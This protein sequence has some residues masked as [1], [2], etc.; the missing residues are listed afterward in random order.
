MSESS[1]SYSVLLQ[2][3]FTL[4]YCVLLRGGS[5]GPH[6]EDWPDKRK[7]SWGLLRGT[8]IVETWVYKNAGKLFTWHWFS[9][10]HDRELPTVVRARYIYISRA[11]RSTSKVNSLP[12]LT[13]RTLYFCAYCMTSLILKAS[14]ECKGQ[15]ACK[16]DIE[17]GDEA[18]ILVM[19]SLSFVLCSRSQ[20]KGCFTT[21]CYTCMPSFL[22]HTQLRGRSS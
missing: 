4:L 15:C 11:P 16:W 18:I 6:K 21:Q 2:Y 8:A 1:S 14:Y 17:S 20:S 13:F 9:W 10:Q 3:K 22:D 5:N 7:R 19:V 12:I